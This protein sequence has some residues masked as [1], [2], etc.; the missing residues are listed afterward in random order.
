MFSY[1]PREAMRATELLLSV[2]QI[3]AA[4]ETLWAH[5][6]LGIHSLAAANAVSLRTAEHSSSRILPWLMKA[7]CGSALDL[8]QLV[9]IALCV[10]LLVHKTATL[11]GLCLMGLAACA[12]AVYVARPFGHDG[13]D[14]MA[15]LTI[16]ALV[17]AEFGGSDRVATICLGFVA[18][19]LCLSYVVAGIAKARGPLWRKGSAISE[20]SRTKSYGA[21]WVARALAGRWRGLMA[22]WFVVGFETLFP[23]ALIHWS[24]MLVFVALGIVFHLGIAVTMGLNNFVWAFGAGY[25]GLIFIGHAF[26]LARL[27][28]IQ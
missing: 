18:A 21:P 1:G 25:P 19:Q 20:I 12:V 2:G 5:R 22:C 8:M 28:W 24:A 23:L 14:Q 3:I 13:A 4:I 27:P 7:T 15:G 6:V 26:A 10:G 11:A 9:R 16:W 17:V